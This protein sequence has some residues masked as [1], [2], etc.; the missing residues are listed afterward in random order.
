MKNWII[1]TDSQVWDVNPSA[2]QEIKRSYFADR[3]PADVNVMQDIV[4]RVHLK[5]V[6]LQTDSLPCAP[7][8]FPLAGSFA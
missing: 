5:S 8:V 6:A 2:Q 4:T 1:P 3:F 7:C